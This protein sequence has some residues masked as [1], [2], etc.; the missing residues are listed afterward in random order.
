MGDA[1][2]AATKYSHENG[3]P[4]PELSPLSTLSP[5]QFEEEIARLLKRDFWL[6]VKVLGGS[7][8]GGIDVAGIGPDGARIVVQCKRYAKTS[9]VTPTQVRDLAGARAMHTADFALLV[10][11]GTLTSQASITARLAKIDVLTAKGIN[12]WRAGTRRITANSEFLSSIQ[13]VERKAK[14]IV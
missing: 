8:D 10:T 6:N 9:F 3:S 2:A 4:I 11:T 1:L 13:Y 7:G 12:R 5:V 14:F